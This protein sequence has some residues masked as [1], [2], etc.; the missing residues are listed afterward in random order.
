MFS[1]KEK[2]T[3]QNF[4]TT[5]GEKN[6]S[7]RAECA[8]QSCCIEALPCGTSVMPFPLYFRETL[9]VTMPMVFLIYFN[10]ILDREFSVNYGL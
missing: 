10:T 6:D 7:I 4:C 9:E 3:K 1:K 5:Y 2:K 8:F